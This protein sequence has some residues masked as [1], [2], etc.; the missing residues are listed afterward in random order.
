MKLYHKVF[1]KIPEIID[2]PD[3]TL[4]GIPIME[5]YGD[6]RIL[7]EGQCAVIQY[8]LNCIRLRNQCGIVSVCG[9][10]L[11]MAELS[12]DRLVVTGRVESVSI[13]KG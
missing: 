7:I 5:I 10:D 6:R 11:C 2:V 3:Q 12:S 1:G 4:P 8:G 9:C 13:T